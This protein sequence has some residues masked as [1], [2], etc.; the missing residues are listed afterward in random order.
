[1]E[2]DTTVYLKD[3]I[4]WGLGFAGLGLTG[5]AYFLKRLLTTLDAVQLACTTFAA[6]LGV[7]EARV[8]DLRDNNKHSA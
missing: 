5:W 6:R 4:N 2:M 3:L 1:M 8:Q 7:V